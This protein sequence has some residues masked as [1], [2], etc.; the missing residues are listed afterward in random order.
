[1]VRRNRQ[2]VE[3]CSVEEPVLETAVDAD[4]DSPAARAAEIRVS[5]VPRLGA[6]MLQSMLD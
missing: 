6:E 1:M 4:V 3:F 5:E 2:P